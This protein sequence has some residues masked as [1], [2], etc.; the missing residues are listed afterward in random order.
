MARLMLVDVLSNLSGFGTCLRHSRLDPIGIEYIAAFAKKKGWDV[1]IEQWGKSDVNE[2]E[3]NILESHPDIVG[4]SMM[5]YNFE[6]YKDVAGRIKKQ[7]RDVKI[8]FGGYYPSSCPEIVQDE[9]IDFVVIGEGE[10]TFIELLETLRCNG[11]FSRVKGIAYWDDGLLINEPRERIDNLDEL[12]F[13]LR[14]KEILK[15]TMIGGLT[16][17]PQSEQVSVCQITYS[18]GCP[19]NCTFCSSPSLWGSQVR[20]RSAE[21][22]VDEIEY[23]QREF[24]TNMIFFTDLTFN[25][26]K[27]KV[28]E[29]CRE[30]LNRGVEINWFAMCHVDNIDIE[31]L[32]EMKKAGCTKISYGIDALNSKTLSKIKPGQKVNIGMMRRALELTSD[33]G[34][35]VRAYVMIGYPWESKES[36]YETKQ[37]IK[38]LPVDDLR[39]SFLTPFPGTPI[40]D[41]FKKEGLI[42]TEDLNKYT[43]DDPTIKVK[44]L[45]SQELI[46]FREEIFKEFYQSKEYE[47]RMN[48]KIKKYPHLKQSYEEFFEFLQSRGVLQHPIFY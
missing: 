7:K 45:T 24:G 5:T 4:F 3:G 2:I 1:K 8:I 41:E 10:R 35:I 20:W 11:D 34:I 14:S 48:N 15:D 27:T 43:S 9:N 38:D 37:V 29:L 22:L 23:L 18:R 39:I 26:N 16:Y 33:M 36:L 6:I 25:L 21:N 40:Y 42:L 47:M 12:P 32:T 44:G 46:N 17:P 19:H 28:L 30:I 13:P 31:I